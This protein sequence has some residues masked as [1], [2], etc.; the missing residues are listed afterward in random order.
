MLQVVQNPEEEHDVEVSQLTRR[1]VHHVE[2]AVINSGLAR[3]VG[4]EEVLDLDAIHRD[5]LRA[6]PLHL[7]AKPSIP[8]PDIK[9]T[10]ST[11]VRWDGHMRHPLI[12]SFDRD[13]SVSDCSIQQIDAVIP[14]LLL[15][16]LPAKIEPPP[17]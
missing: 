10:F 13:Q 7:E 4:V 15:S 12:E 8:R 3:V 1:Q 17:R 9:D 16:Q 14:A 2:N 11:Q 6:A 5:N